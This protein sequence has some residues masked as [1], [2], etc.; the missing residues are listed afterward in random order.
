MEVK[1]VKAPNGKRMN[2]RG[3]KVAEFAK[4]IAALKPGSAIE[5]PW[6]RPSSGSLLTFASGFSGRDYFSY[7]ADNGKVYVSVRD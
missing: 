7:T 2:G 1:I 5:F 3:G 6:A 4:A